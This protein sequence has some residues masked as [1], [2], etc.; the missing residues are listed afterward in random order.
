MPATPS[1]VERRNLLDLTAL[2]RQEEREEPK[3]LSESVR[4][5]QPDFAT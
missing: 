2:G 3:G 1:N 4:K 5:A